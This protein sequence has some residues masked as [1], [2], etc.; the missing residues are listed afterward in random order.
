MRKIYSVVFAAWLRQAPATA[1]S[2]A[3]MEENGANDAQLAVPS[4]FLT[5]DSAC[6]VLGAVSEELQYHTVGIT[7]PSC[8]LLGMPRWASIRR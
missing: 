8:A 4:C 7:T 6:V 2:C 5:L 1:M 3:V